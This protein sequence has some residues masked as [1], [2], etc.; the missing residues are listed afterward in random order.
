[1]TQLSPSPLLSC[2]NLNQQI[3]LPH[4]IF[5]A[6]LRACHYEHWHATETLPVLEIIAD[7]Y[8]FLKGEPALYHLARIK[9]RTTIVVHGVGLNIAS[10]YDLDRDYCYA[11]KDFCNFI[12]PPVISDHLCFS[13]SPSHNSFDLL[14]IPFTNE[15]LNLVSKKIN[16]VQDILKRQLTL[17]NISSYVSYQE[18]SYTEIEFLNELCKRTGCGILLDINNIFVSAFNHGYDPWHEIKK[19]N[20]HYVNQYHI[21]GH[22]QIEDYLFDTHD[23]FACKEVWDL[24]HWALINIG[25]K[26]VI[27]ERDDA[28]VKF[29]DLIFEINYGNNFR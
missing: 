6:G 25:K 10:A 7:N 24:M 16:I 2:N 29:E 17:E 8:M 23:K 28:D 19:V 3:N 26:P 20:P 12:N 15:T 4:G 5:G 1:M 14:P 27:I 13:A 18:N 22:S 11:L 21:A 9:E